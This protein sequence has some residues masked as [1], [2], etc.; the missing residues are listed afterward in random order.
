MFKPIQVIVMQADGTGEVK[1]IS[2]D[3]PVLQKLVGGY[4][5][6]ISTLYDE[7]GRP[8]AMFWCNEEGKIHELPINQKA[9]ALWYAL[10]GER[11]GDYLAGTVILTG[12]PDGD[13]DILPV[14]DVIIKV[15]NAVKSST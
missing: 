14:P 8:N 5:E 4:I 15:W 10:E 1:T 9:T 6:A 13:G 11:T 3:L 7:H 2:Q 12:G